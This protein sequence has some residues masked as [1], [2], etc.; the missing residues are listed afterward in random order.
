MQTYETRSKLGSFFV[1][2]GFIL[3]IASATL[4]LRE[5]FFYNPPLGK[6]SD[7]A[8]ILEFISNELLILIVKIAFLGIII[9]VGSL[10]LKYGL[11]MS[12]GT[13]A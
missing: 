1:I 13:K 8:T 5:Y 4:A 6:A 2:L 9:T 7:I 10:L 11:E 3:L 12:K